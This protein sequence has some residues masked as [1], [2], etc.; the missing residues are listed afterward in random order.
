MSE[1]LEQT[2]PL[3]TT[4]DEYQQQSRALADYPNLDHNLIYPALG[5]A[6]EAG[7]AVDKIKKLWRN[8]GVTSHVN[9]LPAD[10][11]TLVAELGDVLW[12]VAAIASELGLN[13]HTVAGLNLAK[14]LD[15]KARNVIKSEGDNR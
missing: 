7:E 12:Y 14:L 2:I 8:Q 1:K 11:A 5:L 6:G 10:K 4:F 15:R 13:L 9:L 3:I